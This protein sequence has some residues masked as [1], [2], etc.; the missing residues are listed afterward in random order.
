[1]ART[2]LAGPLALTIAGGVLLAGGGVTAIL[3]PLG[4]AQQKA[5]GA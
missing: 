2:D 4:D 5:P 3:M 1:M